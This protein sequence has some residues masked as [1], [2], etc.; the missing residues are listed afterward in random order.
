VKFLIL[1]DMDTKP[2]SETKHHAAI[3]QLAEYLGTIFLAESGR[4]S[5]SY[6]K[7]LGIGFQPRVFTESEMS[8]PLIDPAIFVVD[9]AGWLALGSEIL[10]FMAASHYQPP[11]IQIDDGVTSGEEPPNLCAVLLHDFSE[12]QLFIAIR[13]AFRSTIQRREMD[14]LTGM[15]DSGHSDLQKLIEIGISLSSE[16]NIDRL[17]DKILKEACNVT[18]ADGGSIYIIRINEQ[19]E[20]ILHFSNTWSKSLNVDFKEFTIPIGPNSI[21]G[22]VA[23]TGESLIIDDCYH[24]PKQ[25]A[26]SINRS[27]DESNNYRTKSMLAVAMLN[28]K[29][30][31]TGVIQ[32]INRKPRADLILSSPQVVE[33]T[34]TPF[35]ERSR[36]LIS[37]LASQAAVALENYRLYRDIENLFEGFVQ[38]SVTAIESRD[39]T[40]CGHSERVATLTVGIAEQVN[41]TS[42]GPLKDVHFTENQLKEIRYAALLHDFGKVGVRENVLLKA[43]KLYPDHLE[44]IKKRFEL[45]RQIL[46]KEIFR[47][48]AAYLLNKGYD[49]CMGHFARLDEELK[50]KLETL[51]LYLSLI[52]TANEPAMLANDNFSTLNEIHQ[53]TISDSED[54]SF[55]LLDDEEHRILSIP[56]G[57]LTPEER[58]EMESH[59][60]HSYDFLT[61]IP[62]TRE[63]SNIPEI[64]HGHHEK[65]DGT[66]YPLG[67]RDQGLILQTRM[68]ALADIYDAL[69]AT[70]RPY[71][72]AVPLEKALEI[73][74]HEIETGKLDADLF[75]VFLDGKIYELTRKDKHLNPTPP[76][77]RSRRKKKPTH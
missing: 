2:D 59:V 55:P 68:M 32:L 63:L 35:S 51:D 41:H 31:I 56:R 12:K 21:A 11:L 25:Y 42:T 16:R 28:Q 49:D 71:K 30:E 10:K 19:G 74:R 57:S 46:R 67:A 15:L 22:Y 39:P 24:I 33:E 34:V 7:L 77:P 26:F 18:T 66:G 53:T 70:D 52:I 13:E 73:M 38:A 29:D 14:R 40:T 48:K 9:S 17:L 43:K 50:V 65:L 6:D 75:Q 8:G 20:K 61:K 45:A 4:L 36:S 64:A 60:T 72:P 27:F 58:L 76:S 47:A 62:W 37:A 23:L 1:V 69:T 3:D 44:V 54:A 5:S